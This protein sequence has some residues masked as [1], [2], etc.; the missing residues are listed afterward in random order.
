MRAELAPEA[1]ETRDARRARA[2]THLGEAATPQA[3]GW[4]HHQGSGCVHYVE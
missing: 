4:G 2:S 3:C 1:S